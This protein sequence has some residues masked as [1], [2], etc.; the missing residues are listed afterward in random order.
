MPCPGST[1]GSGPD[2]ASERFGV[3]PQRV[4]D[5]GN[6]NGRIPKRQ[7]TNIEPVSHGDAKGAE[8]GG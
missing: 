5:W 7:R 4:T 2:V 1:L 6:L 3:P 8:Q